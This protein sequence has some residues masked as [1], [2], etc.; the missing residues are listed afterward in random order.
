MAKCKGCDNEAEVVCKTDGLCGDCGLFDEPC[1]DKNC[2]PC[3]EARS[4]DRK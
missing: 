4:Y 1:K 2:K 3:V